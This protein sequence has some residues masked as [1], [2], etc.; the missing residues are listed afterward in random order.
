MPDHQR[1]QDGQHFT[2]RFARLRGGIGFGYVHATPTLC[3]RLHPLRCPRPAHPNRNER[4]FVI[5]FE[6]RQRDLPFF[7]IRPFRTCRF[8]FAVVGGAVGALAV[9]RHQFPQ[10]AA[11]PAKAPAVLE[12][13]DS[14][15]SRSFRPS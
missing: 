4:G 1:A 12:G 7:R 14:A 6:Q 5:A 8:D 9:S 15:A 11:R 2:G 10:R 3:G 13:C